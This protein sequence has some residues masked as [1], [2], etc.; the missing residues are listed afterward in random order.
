MHSVSKEGT[1][2]GGRVRV[3]TES[4]EAMA[5]ISSS[6]SVGAPKVGTA[7]EAVFLRF[8]MA[9]AGGDKISARRS[10]LNI[11]IMTVLFFIPLT[12]IAFWESVVEHGSLKEL[13]VQSRRFRYGRRPNGESPSS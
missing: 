3:D 13:Y 9:V 10:Q 4:D 7:R 1:V 8:L 12:A 11:S 5:V 2:V 6:S